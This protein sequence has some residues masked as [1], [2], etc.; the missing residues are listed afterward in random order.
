MNWTQMCDRQSD[1]HQ[2]SS[3]TSEVKKLGASSDS[4]I[5]LGNSI[6]CIFTQLLKYLCFSYSFLDRVGKY[7]VE[8]LHSHREKNSGNDNTCQYTGTKLNKHGSFSVHDNVACELWV[9]WR[10]KVVS[11]VSRKYGAR[12]CVRARVCVCVW[13]KMMFLTLPCHGTTPQILKLKFPV[14]TSGPKQ[15]LK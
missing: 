9:V 8:I 12:V 15:K 1:N 2:T 13:S 5:Y 6:L 14:H 11:E 10:K 4:I 3:V 7:N